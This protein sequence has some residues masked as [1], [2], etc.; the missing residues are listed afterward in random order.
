MTGD[1]GTLVFAFQ[2][3]HSHQLVGCC[4]KRPH[5][6]QARDHDLKG[7][8]VPPIKGKKT[9]PASWTPSRL[10]LERAREVGFGGS[11]RFSTQTL[12]DI[13]EVAQRD[14]TAART[15]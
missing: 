11:E 2:N 9:M 3:D 5:L 10:P 15:V 6:Q 8:K 4:W 1:V 12:M 14:R 13:L 7:H